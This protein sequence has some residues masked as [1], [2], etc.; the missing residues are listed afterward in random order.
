MISK[1]ENI[2][3]EINI[4]TVDTY[5]YDEPAAGTIHNKNK[6][7]NSMHK[8]LQQRKKELKALNTLY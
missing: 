5:I 7:F 8:M 3:K 1:K 6:V 2:I 4:E